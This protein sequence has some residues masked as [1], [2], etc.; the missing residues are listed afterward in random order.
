[1]AVQVII[2]RKLMTKIFSFFPFQEL[3][4]VLAA[5]SAKANGLTSGEYAATLCKFFQVS[6]VR[7]SLS[8]MRFN[9]LFHNVEKWSNIL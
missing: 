2:L 3:K 7:V 8:C 4:L 1:M 9:P 6:K 5:T